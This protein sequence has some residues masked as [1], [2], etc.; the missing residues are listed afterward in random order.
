[1]VGPFPLPLIGIFFFTAWLTMIFWGI[2][3]PDLGVATIDYGR[4][5]LVTIAL[6][7]ITG[8]LATLL[9]ARGTWMAGG[10]RMRQRAGQLV[11]A[12]QVNLLAV[13]SGST[14]RV[15]TPDFRGGRITAVFGGVQLDL[16]DAKVE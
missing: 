10:Y 12:G 6:W 11:G 3:A 4:A 7:L 9:G 13:L 1:M 5:L 16:R 8:P 2:I 14:R 15:S